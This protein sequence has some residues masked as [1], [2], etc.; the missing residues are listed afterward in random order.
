MLVGT[1]VAEENRST[2]TIVER[3]ATFERM[4]HKEKD[5]ILSPAEPPSQIALELLDDAHGDGVNDLLMG[6]GIA[7]AGS[8]A[9]FRQ[10]P[11]VVEVDGPVPVLTGAVV[12]HDVNQLAHRARLQVRLKRYVDVQEST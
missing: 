9:A 4:R 6:S 2:L 11:L 3:I 8:K 5:P 7:L 1:V 10:D 12:V